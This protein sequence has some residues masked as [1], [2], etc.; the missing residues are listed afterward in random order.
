MSSSAPKPIT[1]ALLLCD[2]PPPAVVAAH[3]RYDDIFGTLLAASVPAGLQYSVEAYDVVEKMDY[4]PDEDLLDG[5]LIT[6]SGEY[7]A[8]S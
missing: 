1:L 3:G 2:T 5:I 7:F 4:P 6:G 8:C